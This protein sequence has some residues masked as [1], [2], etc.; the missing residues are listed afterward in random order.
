MPYTWL[1]YSFV[2]SHI[3]IIVFVL[4]GWAFRITRK[5]HLALIFVTLFSWLILGIWY[6]YGYCFWN[7]WHWQILEKMG[8]SDLPSSFVK[9]VLDSL[10]GRDW[11]PSTV[12]VITALALLSVLC[13]SVYTNWKDSY[14]KK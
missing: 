7:D 6:G 1:H 3:I 11:D 9:F 12:D 10:S 2:V 5:A 8:R 13:L 4:V 14:R